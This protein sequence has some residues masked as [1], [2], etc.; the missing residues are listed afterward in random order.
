MALLWKAV[1]E[2][3]AGVDVQLSRSEA[4]NKLGTVHYASVGERTGK[5]SYD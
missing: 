5:R 1:A 4:V 3:V 2:A